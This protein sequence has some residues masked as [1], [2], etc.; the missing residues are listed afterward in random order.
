V[1][2]R[3][4]GQTGRKPAVVINGGQQAWQQ[5]TG[6]NAPCGR[7]AVFHKGIPVRTVGQRPKKPALEEADAQ[8]ARAGHSASMG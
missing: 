6:A 8:S 5:E 3:A 7:Q 1:T 2:N 4:I